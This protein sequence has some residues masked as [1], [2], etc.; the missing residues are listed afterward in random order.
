MAT[1]Y[2][3]LDQTGSTGHAGT[4]IDPYTLEDFQSIITNYQIP[5]TFLMRGAGTWTGSEFYVVHIA[6]FPDPEGR[7]FAILDKWGDD[8]WRLRGEFI[9]GRCVIRNG[10]VSCWG[11]FLFKAI[12]NS[13]IIKLGSGY[14]G[15]FYLALGYSNS[16]IVG[17]LIIS[18]S[19]ITNGNSQWRRIYY[20]RDSIIQGEGLLTGGSERYSPLITENSLFTAST[21]TCG[22]EG[23]ETHSNSQF[24]WIPPIFP[25]WNAPLEEWSYVKLFSGKSAIPT[26]PHPGVM[27]PDYGPVYDRFYNINSTSYIESYIEEAES[28]MPWGVP[29]IGIGA[30]YMKV[31]ADMNWQKESGECSNASDLLLKFYNFA[32]RPVNEGGAGWSVLDEGASYKVITDSFIGTPNTQRK[33]VKVVEDGS[34]IRIYNYLGFSDTT[35]SLTGLWSKY[36]ME[37][38]SGRNSL[39]NFRGG[40]GTIIIQNRPEYDWNVIAITDFEGDLALLESKYNIGGA[41]RSSAVTG[42]HAILDLSEDYDHPDAAD[43]DFG[44]VEKFTIGN[45]YYIYDMNEHSWVDY[46]K[47]EAID[48]ENNTLTVDSIAYDYPVGA[49]ISPYAHQF[50]SFGTGGNSKLPYCS[51]K[52]NVFYNQGGDDIKGAVSLSYN[53]T[54]LSH[55]NSTF[56]NKYSAQFPN[57]VE[58]LNENGD[59]INM[60]R[61]YGTIKNLLVSKWGVNIQGAGGC[62]LNGLRYMSFQKESDVMHDGSDDKAI[63]ILDTEMKR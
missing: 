41:L 3:D 4:E 18:D 37:I 55:A 49:V 34:F 60:N 58:M 19:T 31:D 5:D 35:K 48:S 29:R 59:G 56:D 8:P 13:I 52:N 2:V 43:L 21:F 10:I 25:E 15:N 28:A 62:E 6:K 7:G 17:S 54:M 61:M 39:Y 32:L 46:V 40:D 30:G 14:Y 1:Y 9:V 44:R 57:V 63:M 36:N 11:A 47:V 53:D 42:E 27:F 22:S 16:H 24:N 20:I 51:D 50:F 26:P 45:W 12:V 23:G 33:I 38:P